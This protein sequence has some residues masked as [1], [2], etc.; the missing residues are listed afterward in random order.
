[1]KTDDAEFTQTSSHLH[2][3]LLSRNAGWPCTGNENAIG[4]KEGALSTDLLL[5]ACMIS[6]FGP[7]APFWSLL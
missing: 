5:A 2:S 4:C 1:L 6:G 7:V 3:I